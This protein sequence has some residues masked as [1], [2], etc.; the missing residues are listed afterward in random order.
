[1]IVGLLLLIFANSSRSGFNPNISTYSCPIDWEVRSLTPKPELRETAQR[2]QQNSRAC[3]PTRTCW[4][5]ID[6]HNNQPLAA[7]NCCCYMQWPFFSLRLTDF[8]SNLTFLKYSHSLASHF[9]GFPI[10]QGL[11]VFVLFCFFSFIYLTLKCC[12]SSECSSHF[13]CPF[14]VSPQVSSLPL[15]PSNFI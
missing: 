5:W 10:F 14:Y 15:K 2:L 13:S 6:K 8:S 1:M 3:L 12:I 7:K 11:S 4:Y 9:P